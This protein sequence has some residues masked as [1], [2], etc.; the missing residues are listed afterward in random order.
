[1]SQPPSK[2]HGKAGPGGGWSARS[3][4]SGQYRPPSPFSPTGSPHPQRVHHA[5]PTSPLTYTGTRHPMSPVPI[6]MPISPGISPVFGSPTGYIQCPRPRWPS[7]IPVT[8]QAPRP[9]IPTQV[10]SLFLKIIKMNLNL[11][12]FVQ[13]KKWKGMEFTYIREF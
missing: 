11:F 4:V 2:P 6:G 5:H 7:P 12:V 3:N 1:M 9:F 13:N 10:H 8:T